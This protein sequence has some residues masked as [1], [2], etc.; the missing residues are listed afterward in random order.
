MSCKECECSASFGND[1]VIL[2]TCNWVKKV[3]IQVKNYND[4]SLYI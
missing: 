4:K 2:V 1:L 3:D